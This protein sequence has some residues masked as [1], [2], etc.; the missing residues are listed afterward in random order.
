MT[1]E[2]KHENLLNNIKHLIK[3]LDEKGIKQKQSYSD[4]NNKFVVEEVDWTIYEDDPTI[5]FLGVL[6]SEE[7]RDAFLY[8]KK[9]GAIDSGVCWECGQSPI[10]ND[11]KF[12]PD[13]KISFFIC[14]D[15]VQGIGNFQNEIKGY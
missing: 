3:L 2:Q 7:N 11:Y 13:K 15:C 4:S 14:K 6:C 12:S 1:S 5:T 9:I 8:L 10:T